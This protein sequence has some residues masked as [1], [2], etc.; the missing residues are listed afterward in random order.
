MFNKK[1]QKSLFN[2]VDVS[3]STVYDFTLRCMPIVGSF[4]EMSPLYD[5]KSDETETIDNEFPNHEE[6]KEEAA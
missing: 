4:T 2:P 5:N 6:I 3:I 1:K